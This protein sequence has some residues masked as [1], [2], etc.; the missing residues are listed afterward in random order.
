MQVRGRS[1]AEVRGVR[2]GPS[3]RETTQRLAEGVSQVDIARA[4]LGHDRG[5]WPVARPPILARSGRRGFAVK[6]SE[7][8]EARAIFRARL[9]SSSL[10]S[11]AQFLARGVASGRR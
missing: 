9:V 11:R 8:I 6:R 10:S 1:W 2:F 7:I 4:V 5:V 3:A